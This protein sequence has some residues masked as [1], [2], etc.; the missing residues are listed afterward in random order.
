MP[1]RRLLEDDGE[2]ENEGGWEPPTEWIPDEQESDETVPCPHCGAMIYEQAEQCPEC[3][4][5]ITEEEDIPRKR[6]WW[7]VVGLSMAFLVAIMW[8]LRG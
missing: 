4:E 8:V 6:P 7:V 3:S 1:R 5:Y 2:G